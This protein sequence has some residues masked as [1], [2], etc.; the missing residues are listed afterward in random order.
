MNIRTMIFTISMSLMLGCTTT[1]AQQGNIQLKQASAAEFK[2]AI[3]SK[4]GQLIDIRTPNEYN[5][6]HIKGAILVDFYSPAYKTS[7]DKL[8]KT[9]P[10]Y[11]YC[12]SGNRSGKSIGLLEE[13][14]FKQVVNLQYGIVD[15]LRAGF[16]LT[17]AQ[18]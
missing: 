5:S 9:K 8:D 1:S 17:P 12:R 10:V 11:M 14:G 2:E 15:W 4:K 7:L 6:G 13:L 3:T 16:P 18:Q